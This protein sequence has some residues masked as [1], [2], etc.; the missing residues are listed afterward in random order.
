MKEAGPTMRDEY[1]KRLQFIEDFRNGKIPLQ[2][3][4]LLATP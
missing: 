4:E 3:Q 2:Q 1:Y